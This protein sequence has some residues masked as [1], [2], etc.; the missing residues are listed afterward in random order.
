P[1][2]TL[3]PYTT[4]FRSWG[5]SVLLAHSRFSSASSASS[6]VDSEALSRKNRGGR[7]GRRGLLAGNTLIPHYRRTLRLVK[8]YLNE[9]IPLLHGLRRS[10]FFTRDRDVY[11]P[12]LAH[13]NH[14]LVYLDIEPV[15]NSAPITRPLPTQLRQLCAILGKAFLHTDTG[16]IADED[17]GFRSDGHAIRKE[18]PSTSH[19]LSEIQSNVNLEAHLSCNLSPEESTHLT[20]SSNNS[21]GTSVG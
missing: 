15:L 10:T 17:C 16:R 14:C 6:A 2:S 1:R 4:L 20:Y 5:D 21:A 12:G 19:L 18:A 7:R 13:R 11:D 9:I 8:T 3:F